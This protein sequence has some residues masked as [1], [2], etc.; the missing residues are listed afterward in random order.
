MRVLVGV[1]AKSVIIGDLTAA[2]FRHLERGL[3]FALEGAWIPE[4]ERE[5]VRSLSDGLSSVAASGQYELA[6]PLAETPGPM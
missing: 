4:P 2:E 3:R 6:L 1:P 5:A